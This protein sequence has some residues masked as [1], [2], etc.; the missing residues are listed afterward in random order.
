MTHGLALSLGGLLCLKRYAARGHWPWLAMAGALVGLTSLTK[1]EVFLASSIALVAGAILA[2]R[3]ARR[4]RDLLIFAAC[5][6]AIP[7]I[8][9]VLLSL[10]M[11]VTPGGHGDFWRVAM[12]G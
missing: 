11:P 3:H 8:A 12:G 2:A 7:G 9:V 4:L 10:A 1:P 5:A 6:A